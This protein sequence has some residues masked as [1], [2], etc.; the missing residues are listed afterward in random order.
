VIVTS[1][2]FSEIASAC[3][4]PTVSVHA[5]IDPYWAELWSSG[6]SASWI[7][8]ALARQR[9][10][11]GIGRIPARLNTPEDRAWSQLLSRTAISHTLNVMGVLDS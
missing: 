7:S 2:I 6:G 5:R 8:L 10:D 1:L 3:S 11:A 4:E 9:A